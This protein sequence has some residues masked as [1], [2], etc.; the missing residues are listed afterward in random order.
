MRLP[1]EVSSRSSTVVVVAPGEDHET[2]ERIKTLFFDKYLLG[3]S[4]HWF[5]SR[6]LF[7]EVTP[8]RVDLVDY[9]KGFGH[10]DILVPEFD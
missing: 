7:Y 5:G 10:K 8:E 9:S 6:V 2:I 3:D 1:G 4:A